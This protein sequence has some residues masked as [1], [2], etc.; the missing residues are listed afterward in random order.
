MHQNL[1][2]TSLFWNATKCEISHKIHIIANSASIFTL[3]RTQNAWYRQTFCKILFRI[4][5]KRI[6]PR[7]TG[8]LSRFQYFL[9]KQRREESKNYYRHDFI[10][11][12]FGKRE[13][14][15]GLNKDS[16][17]TGFWICNYS[18]KKAKNTVA[19]TWTCA[20]IILG[21]LIIS[22][23]KAFKAPSTKGREIICIFLYIWGVILFQRVWGRGRTNYSGGGEWFNIGFLERTFQNTQN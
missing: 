19:S 15:G 11:I 18:S 23:F 13:G 1:I 4:F 22:K 6:N 16:L 17:L 5:P 10:C 3:A 7:K 12:F 9:L 21:H 8:K 20:W 2:G 14:R